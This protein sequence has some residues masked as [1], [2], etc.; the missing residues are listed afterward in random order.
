MLPVMW[1]GS[2]EPHQNHYAEAAQRREAVP[3]TGTV[4][5]LQ[6][7]ALPCCQLCCVCMGKVDSLS[8]ELWQEY[9]VARTTGGDECQVSRTGVPRSF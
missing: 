4:S 3:N 5:L 9:T 6:Q 7:V 8:E 1:R 2:T